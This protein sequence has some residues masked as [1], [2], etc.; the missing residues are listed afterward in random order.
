[1]KSALVTALQMSTSSTSWFASH[2]VPLFPFILHC[3]YILKNVTIYMSVIS[4]MD[5]DSL[6]SYLLV[7]TKCQM[8]K[9]VVD[10]RCLA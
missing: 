5:G 1:M 7:F 2:S 4:V 10:S 6:L 8:S 9:T 3:T